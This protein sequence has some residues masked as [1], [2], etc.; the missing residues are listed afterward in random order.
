MS[1]KSSQSTRTPC[2]HFSARIERVNIN[3][4][5]NSLRVHFSFPPRGCSSEDPR[6]KLLWC[7]RLLR[8]FF[9]VKNLTDAELQRNL[10]QDYERKF[11]QLPED[12]KLSEL[13][14]DAG[15]KIVEK[16]QFFITLEE[17]GP[18][19][20]KNLC[21]ENTTPRSEEAS[22][23]KGW[24]LGNTKICRVFDVKVCLHQKRYNIEIMVESLFRDR[25][26]SWVRIVNGLTN[27]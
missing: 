23:V 25:T 26:V 5:I 16:G 2:T 4:L 6:T 27:T 24:I 12:Q 10:L 20:M 14:S 13:C 17:E 8:C 15:L 7:L 19:E 22:R 21:R 11:E 9:S 18:D 3:Q 1:S